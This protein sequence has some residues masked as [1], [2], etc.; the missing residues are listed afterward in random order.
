[1]GSVHILDAAGLGEQDPRAYIIEQL[2]QR[3]HLMPSMT[4]KLYDPWYNPDRPIWVRDG[5]F[6][7]SDHVKT[8]D[9]VAPGGDIGLERVVGSIFEDR[10]PRDR[11]LWQ[12]WVINDADRLRDAGELVVVWKLHHALMDGEA[13]RDV[14]SHIADLDFARKPDAPPM[15]GAPPGA[16]AVILSS[17]A[18]KLRRLRTLPWAISQTARMV[19][20]SRTGPKSSAKSV[21]PRTSLNRTLSRSR[22]WSS[23]D[24]EL[25]EFKQVARHYGVTINDVLLCVVGG[26][27]RAMFNARGEQVDQSLKAAMTMAIENFDKGRYATESAVSAAIVSI[28]LL[29]TIDDPVARLLA[30]RDHTAEAKVHN[31]SVGVNAFRVWTEFVAGP[32]LRSRA[33]LAE[34]VRITELT[35]PLANVVVSNHRQDYGP[36]RFGLMQ[37]A[38]YSVGPLNHDTGVTLIACSYG[39]TMGV[40]LIA[41]REQL[42]EPAEVTDA[43]VA[44]FRALVESVD[45]Q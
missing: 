38:Q 16:A 26:G 37:R 20:E 6:D 4:Q 31:R 24:M 33:L 36:Y 30:I 19:R 41:C 44:Q 22:V 7:L 17:V 45:R 2:R 34:H 39:G 9:M 14:F 21:T 8:V 40:G 29:D 23:A 1:M 11:P 15:V 43:I 32:V 10:L 3:I 42:A 27:L 13:S 35:R 28:D 5:A 18:V 25:A 12:L